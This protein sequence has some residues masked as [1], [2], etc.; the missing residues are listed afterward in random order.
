MSMEREK[1][2][3]MIIDYIDEKLNTVDRHML[4]QELVQNAEAFKLYEQL[5]AVM[6]AMDKTE[7]LVPSA[8]LKVKF[9]EALRKA[10]AGERKTKTVFFT[11]T[12]YRV[13]ATV[14]L[15]VV[16]GGV[17]YFISEQNRDRNEL[18]ALKEEMALTRQ[19]VF[20]K[21]NDDQSASQR[22][23]GVKAAYE[24]VTTSRPDD[25][26]VEALVTLL[27][28][29]SNSNVRLTALDALSRFA[30]EQNVRTA[31]VQSLGK[32]TDPVVQIALIQLLVQL[33]E[34]DAMK[35]LQQII[36]DEQ[37]LPAVKDEAHVGIFKLT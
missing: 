29:D 5:R 34:K 13:A 37:S 28:H 15:L 6:Q 31:L 7:S 23:L 10:I 11:P 21:L 19:L 4:E 32:Q 35:S 12:F 9:D 3:S 16:G 22:M 20:D 27:N 36:D 14:A 33:K 25:E 18:I 24:S 1:L 17:G 30:T 8:V 26:I 2:E